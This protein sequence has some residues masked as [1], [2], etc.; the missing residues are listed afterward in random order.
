MIIQR[1]A[2]SLGGIP[3]AGGGWMVRCPAHDDRTPSLSIDLGQNGNP[4]VKC[5]S[6]C[7]NEAVI[8][9]LRSSG[10]WQE[11][12]TGMSEEA[13]CGSLQRSEKRKEERQ[14]K[15]D[16]V[17]ALAIEVWRQATQAKDNN[18]YLARKQERPTDTLRQIELSELVKHIGYR[19]QT[20]GEPLVEGPILIAP[21][22]TDGR[23]STLEMIDGKGRKS[24][25]AGGKKSGGFWATGKLPEGTGEDLRIAIGEGIATCLTA[26][27]ATGNL[28]VAALSCGNI[29]AVARQIRERYPKGE[30]TLLAE[31][32]KKTGNPD[33]HAFEAA[34]A[35]DGKL[36]VPDF[37]PD[38]PEAATDFNDLKMLKGQEAVRLCL[39]SATAP[40]KASAKSLAETTGAQHKQPEGKI[41]PVNIVDFLGLEFPPR[42]NLI[43]PW[44]PSQGLAM[45]FAARGIGKTHFALGVAY[46][47]AS[48][49]SFLGWQAPRPAGVLYID[50]EMPAVVMQERLAAIALSNNKEP[51]APF[52]LLTPDLQ[53]GGMPRID[54]EEGQHAIESILTEDIK[55]IVIDNIS[56][57]SRAKENEADGWTP[58]Q[59]WAL[60]QR[61]IGRS[62]LFV[63]HSG[64][65]GQQRGTS[66]R[67]DVLD[68]VISLKRPTDYQSDQGAVFEIHFEKAR[69]IYGDDV[70]PIE[71]TLST[72][73]EGRSI[74]LTRTVEAGTYERVVRLLK[75]GMRQSEIAEELGLH[76]SNISRHAKR[77]MEEGLIK[78]DEKKSKSLIL[79]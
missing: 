43:S 24:A 15:A 4:I 72:D 39:E 78:A 37:G 22:M 26:A 57:L 63:H 10:L 14:K 79:K 11:G 27:R 42:K 16:Q 34:A 52:I 49:G 73:D 23:F 3:K 21:V 75:E 60:R 62:V 59:A 5:F 12:G 40:G 36:A 70:K 31:L 66:R 32:N 71:A 56:T 33:P 47:V 6:G 13:I 58:I 41:F 51:S 38:R 61:A 17:A 35:I 76:K 2:E 50:G 77:A 67:E 64:K 54:T 29:M 8:D 53:D 68:T 45:V 28:T 30:I 20:H 1:I 7:S 48:G 9:K 46:A 19:P 18:P 65:G 69:G 25:L 55:L 44:L 74:W